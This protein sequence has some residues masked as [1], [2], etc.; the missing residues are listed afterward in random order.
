MSSSGSPKQVK[1]IANMTKKG[2]AEF[3]EKFRE[4]MTTMSPDDLYEEIECVIQDCLRESIGFDP[5]MKM[6]K[7]ISDKVY[8][9]RKENLE[10]EGVSAYEKYNKPYRERVKQK[11][12]G[13]STTILYN[14]PLPILE[15]MY[16]TV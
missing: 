12:P 7:E 16:T 3:V 6:P 8:K 9:Q 5:N 4:R 14:N 10:K 13:V 1:S 2:Y 15:K 11:F